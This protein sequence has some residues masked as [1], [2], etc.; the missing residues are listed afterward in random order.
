MASPGWEARCTAANDTCDRATS[1]WLALIKPC[2]QGVC[3]CD[4]SEDNTSCLMCG[5]SI[6]IYLSIHPSTY[7]S[8]HLSIHP[9]IHPSIYPSIHLSIY[10]SIHLSIYPSIHLSI[11]LSAYLPICL[12]AYLPIYLSTYLPIYLSTYLPIYLSLSASPPQRLESII[13]PMERGGNGWKRSSKSKSISQPLWICHTGFSHQQDQELRSSNGRHPGLTPVGRSDITMIHLCFE[14]LS[15]CSHALTIGK[16]INGELSGYM[17]Y[18]Y[19][20]MCVCLC[21]YRMDIND[22]NEY[23]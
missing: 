2:R 11:C 10:P 1:A 17:I 13:L 21:V 12:S 8:I 16:M 4:D 18:I 5:N 3:G 19:I 23:K 15:V 7:P 9:S 6:S 20:Y 14:C 22:I